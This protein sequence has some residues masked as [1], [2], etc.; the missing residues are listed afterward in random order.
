MKMEMTYVRHRCGH[1][2]EWEIGRGETAASIR[3]YRDGTL[4]TRCYRI[5][6]KAGYSAAGIPIP[7][8]YDRM[9]VRWQPT[10]ITA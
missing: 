6:K 2:Q 1:V 9:G 10:K 3:Q 8:A 5:E 7:S 4:C